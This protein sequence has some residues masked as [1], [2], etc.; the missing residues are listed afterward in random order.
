VVVLGDSFVA[1]N[2]ACDL[3]K[4]DLEVGR[5]GKVSEADCRSVPPT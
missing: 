5:R 3:V 4:V 1:A 2:R